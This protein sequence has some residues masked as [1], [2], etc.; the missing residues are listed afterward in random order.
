[1][2]TLSLMVLFFS[3]MIL[4]NQ[5]TSS[6]RMSLRI[7]SD[8]LNDTLGRLG[9]VCQSIV[10]DETV[11][12]INYETTPF[13][14]IWQY[15]KLL[16]RLAY[17]T[18]TTEFLPTI[19]VFF[20][21]TNRLVSSNSGLAEITS[22]LFSNEFGVEDIS[23]LERQ[24]NRWVYR[25]A[26]L[27]RQYD[28]LMYLTMNR[29]SSAGNAIVAVLSVDI[30]K[31]SHLLQSLK[32]QDGIGTAFLVTDK[33]I[34][35]EPSIRYDRLNSVRDIVKDKPENDGY[36]QMILNGE[37]V[38][39]VYSDLG[40][41]GL[42]L[43]MYINEGIIMEPFYR[44]TYL[45]LAFA[46]I[47]A[48]F[49]T[50][51]LLWSYRQFLNPMKLLIEGI[52]RVRN[53]DL[54]TRLPETSIPEFHLVY[55][56][57]N[58]ML[59]KTNQLIDDVYI[60]ELKIKDSRLKL[61]ESQ[62]NPHF[63]YNCL[64]YIYLMSQNENPQATGQMSF[65]LGKYFRNTFRSANE[66]IPFSEEIEN[67]HCYL[68]IQKLRFGHN[69]ICRLS[70][71][72]ESLAVSIPRLAVLTVIENAFVHGIE[73]Q[74]SCG[75]LE[76]SAQIENGHLIVKVTNNGPAL[77]DLRIREINSFLA[78]PETAN[79]HFGLA[80]T[81]WR[82]RYQLGMEAMLYLV[83]NEDHTMSTIMDIP[84]HPVLPIEHT[85]GN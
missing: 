49:M 72:Q 74:P 67:V 80:S 63:L 36:S 44:I 38:L 52:D 33:I 53:G 73:K 13:D 66:M 20:A 18:S 15:S 81:I 64:N 9:T 23:Q 46:L 70:I 5:I 57:F 71:T 48:A 76:I 61:L 42:T 6:A 85:G 47:F 2:L 8:R 7:M 31:L 30:G 11:N 34:L 26:T 55:Q 21:K 24:T 60:S 65:Y 59:L 75:I 32:L 29:T 54:K 62:I 10:T 78:G 16:D 12:A 41:P 77:D 58:D 82:I 69:L 43:G 3:S 56:Q 79:E 45:I 1:M 37:K 40:Q 39:L 22:Q 19:E 51:I 4:K 83:H 28:S 35:S 84:A 14:L 27:S 68:E 25:H 50:V 17:T